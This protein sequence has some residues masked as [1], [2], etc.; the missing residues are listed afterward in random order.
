MFKGI[1]ASSGIAVGK[2]L[3]LEKDEVVIQSVVI[4]NIEEEKSKFQ[5]ALNLSK[6]QIES[7]KNKSKDEQKTIL[8]AHIMILEDPEFI[9]SV[10]EKISSKKLNVEA[11]LEDALKTFISIFESMEDEYMRERAADIRDV[12]QRVMT[13]LLGKEM[14]NLAELTEPV[15]IV[16]YD[17]TPSDTAQ[18]DNSKV[19]GFITDIGGRTSHSAIMARSMEIPAVVGLGNIT[20]EVKTGDFIVFDGNEGTVMINP[21]ESVITA[22]EKSKEKQIFEKRELMKLVNTP[23]VSKD[24][25]TVE[26]GANIGGQKD[27]EKASENGAE[28][29]GLYRTEFLYMDRKAL[30]TEEEQ[31]AAYKKALEIMGKRPVIIRTLDIG[32]DKEL[33]YMNLPKEMNPFLGYRAIRICLKE[34]EIFRTQLRALL[35]A[36]VY[37]N[38]KIM[39][40]MISSIEEIRQANKILEEVKSEL[41]KEG[42]RYSSDIEVGI[43]IEIPAAAIIS[44]LLAKEV[45]FFSIGTNDL[46][47]Y[48][49]AVDRMNENVSYLYN[50]FNPAVLR[51]IKL[52]IDNGHKAGIWVGMCGEAAGDKRLIP[53]L[54][55]MG[56]DEFSMS[57]GSILS[58]RRQIQNLS[59]SKMRQVV[60]KVLA[61]STAE[62]IEEFIGQYI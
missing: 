45:D 10:E 23:T 57:A 51:L 1:G 19:L 9:S 28:G 39:Y 25:K 15:I 58:A 37:G 18:M 62:A 11:A 35:R 56:L 31:F 34:K 26:L 20:K 16:A 22:Y 36:S 40:P 6:Q 52:I 3:V 54:L 55:G 12:G 46:I 5:R 29:I 38:L 43:M 24:E 50:P 21:E 61:M 30:P 60:D 2:A 44:D 33:P 32:G 49:T 27:A 17:I 8:D 47:Q 14:L 53:I 4:D 59:Y 41:E 48:T 13:N 7:I 42:I